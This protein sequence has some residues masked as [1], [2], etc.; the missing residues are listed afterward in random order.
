MLREFGAS[1]NRIN[2]T[3]NKQLRI[4]ICTLGTF[5]DWSIK[6]APSDIVPIQINTF[7]DQHLRA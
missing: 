3:Y 5:N 6:T 4:P 1:E 2:R 7:P